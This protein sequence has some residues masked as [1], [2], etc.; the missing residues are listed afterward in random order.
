MS[1][2]YIILYEHDDADVQNI[3]HIYTFIYLP[4]YRYIM[5]T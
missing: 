3:L 1:R 4:A 2:R 5:Y